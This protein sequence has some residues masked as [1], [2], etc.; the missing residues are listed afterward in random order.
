[1]RLDT[2]EH[3]AELLDFAR[4]LHHLQAVTTP[5]SDSCRVITSI[6]QPLQRV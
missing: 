4:A 5:K 3:L 2:V 6:L 1:M